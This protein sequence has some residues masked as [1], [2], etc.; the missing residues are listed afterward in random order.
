MMFR[1]QREAMEYHERKTRELGY[2]IIA[3]AIGLV[4]GVAWNVWI[5]G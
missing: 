5:V 2:L 1:S 3:A 4:L